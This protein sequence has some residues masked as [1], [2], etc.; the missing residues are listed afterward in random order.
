MRCSPHSVARVFFFMA[1]VVTSV[2]SL[3]QSPVSYV[4]LISFVNIFKPHSP[5][6]LSISPGSSSSSP[7]AFLFVGRVHP[8]TGHEGP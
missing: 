6:N 4:M 1:T 3:G 5:N 8:V 7:V 2:K